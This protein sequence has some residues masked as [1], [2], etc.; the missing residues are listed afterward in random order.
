MNWNDGEGWVKGAPRD[1]NASE[2]PAAFMR[3][4]HTAI[5]VFSI[6]LYLKPFL[7]Q[8]PLNPVYCVK[9]PVLVRL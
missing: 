9:I 4:G 5:P 1:V 7:A 6:K 2:L 8:V 3:P